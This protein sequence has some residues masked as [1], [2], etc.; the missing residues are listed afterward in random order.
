M[1]TLAAEQGHL[2]TLVDGLPDEEFLPEADDRFY[3]ANQR[4]RPR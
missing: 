3:S 4:A 1:L 2:L